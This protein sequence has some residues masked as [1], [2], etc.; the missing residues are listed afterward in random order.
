M[1]YPAY[2]IV[3]FDKLDYC[4]SLKNTRMLNGTQNFTFYKGD[5]TNENEVLDCLGRHNIDTI[6]HF[7]A[8]SHVDQSF[9][10]SY[11]FTHTNVYST[12]V[13]L[14]SA[15]KVGIKQFIHV[16]TGEVYGEAKDD[17][18]DFLKMRMLALTNPYT[19]SKAAAEMLV[20]SY[21]KSFNIPVIIVVVPTCL[22]HTNIRRKSSP[23][24][25]SSSTGGSLSRSRA[26]AV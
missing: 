8:Q 10:N 15:R 6:I 4:S 7:A 26:T 21:L 18:S 23:S 25:S 17:D 3:S 12:H 11:K 13:L 5:I 9:C 22:V 2:N 24:S 1:T 14:E 19:A 16:L 20:H